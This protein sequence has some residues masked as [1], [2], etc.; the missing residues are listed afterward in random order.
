MGSRYTYTCIYIYIYYWFFSVSVT[1]LIPG[2][3]NRCQDDEDAMKTLLTFHPDGDRPGHVKEHPSI[4]T[5]HLEESHWVS[6]VTPI[7]KLFVPFIGRGPKTLLRGLTY[8]H[9]P[10]PP[11][12]DVFSHLHF[13]ICSLLPP[14]P[15]KPDSCATVLCSQGFL[16]WNQFSYSA[17]KQEH[18]MKKGRSSG[19]F[20]KLGYPKM[21]GE[22]N[23][24]PY[25]QM[26]DLGGNPPI[27]GFPPIWKQ[28]L[29]KQNP[30]PCNSFLTDLFWDGENVTLFFKD[31]LLVTSN[32]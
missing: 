25:E 2:G 27:F 19:G 11:F 13:R 21:D 24:K 14:T 7:Y 20:L 32:N 9:I 12:L 16:Q 30:P 28:I 31:W 1:S 15:T 10:R 29:Q 8:H 18:G 17:E 23:G 22:N 5:Q 26:D 4:F 3:K 6:I